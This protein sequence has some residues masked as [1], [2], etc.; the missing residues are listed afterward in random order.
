MRLVVP[1]LLMYASAIAGAQNVS[2]GAIH[3]TVRDRATGIG[4]PHAPV[5]ISGAGVSDIV[6]TSD[7]GSYEIDSLEPGKYY[8]DYQ[9]NTMQIESS[10][11]LKAD[12]SVQLDFDVRGLPHPSPTVGALF[13]KI[14]SMDTGEPLVDATVEVTAE[15]GKPEVAVTDERGLY[16]IDALPPGEYDVRVRYEDAVFYGPHVEVVAAK[17]SWGGVRV[18]NDATAIPRASKCP[19]TAAARVHARSPRRSKGARRGAKPDQGVRDTFVDI[20]STVLVLRSSD[21]APFGLR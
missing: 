12:E 5:A 18:R 20:H 8:I 13:G 17:T 19:H 9:P 10:V 21:L 6:W 11:T 3:G 4:V 1:A 14:K 15:C 2:T 7:D 16:S